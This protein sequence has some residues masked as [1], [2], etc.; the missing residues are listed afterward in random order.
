MRKHRIGFTLVEVA[1]FLAITGLLFMMVT[2]GV[3][4]SIYQQRYNEAVQSF[5]DF[6]GNLYAEVMNV[7]SNNNGR[8]KTAMYGKLVVFN[9]GN[10]KQEIRVYDVD[11]M[12]ANSAELETGTTL[13]LLKKLGADVVRK[14]KEELNLYVPVGI[15]EIYQ[16]K[17]GA[18]IQKTDSFDDF[19]GSVLIVRDP[20]SGVV[21]TYVSKQTFDVKDSYTS[22]GK[23]GVLTNVLTSDEFK[24]NDVDFCINPNGEAESNNRADI[25]LKRR[26]Q[27]QSGIEIM[28][29]DNENN[30]CNEVGS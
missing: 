10:E 20:K 4:N 15:I 12:A 30:R 24:F 17:W 29:F 23:P 18:R 7:Q 25:R 13:E 27:N 16:P 26:A 6:I 5:A 28:S 14:S 3:Q 19:E 9:K 8:T 22:E 21:Q 1:L 2:V 11:G